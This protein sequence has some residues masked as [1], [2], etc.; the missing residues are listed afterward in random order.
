MYIRKEDLG[1]R[2]FKNEKANTQD[3]QPKNYKDVQK[4][5]IEAH[6]SSWSFT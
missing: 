4:G 1:L 2:S 6:V 3:E 5:T